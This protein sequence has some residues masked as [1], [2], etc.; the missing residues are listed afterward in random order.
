MTGLLGRLGRAD[1]LL[2]TALGW[3]LA[4]FLRYAFPPLFEPLQAVYGVSNAE[5]GAAFTGLM[6]VYAAM[7]FPSGLLADRLG[8]VTVITTGVLVAGAA[9]FALVVDSP[10]PVL[11]GAMLL[12]GAGTG[13][14]KTVAVRLLAGVYPSRTGWA[15]GVIDTFGAFGGVAAPATVV[16]FLGLPGV[17]GAP[18]RTLFLVAGLVAVALA[19]AFVVRAWTRTDER[20][21]ADAGGG[22]D[23]RPALRQYLALFRERRFAAFAALAVL[24]SFGYSGFV[25]FL[26]LYLTAEARLAASTAS[27][28]YSALFAVS[29][30]Q[31]LTGEASDRVG[32][33]PVVGVT[34]GVAT[35]ALVA[36]VLLTASGDAVLLGVAAV[37]MG[38]GAHG[39]RPV[40]GAYLVSIV[41]EATAGGSLGVVR[42]LL[43]AGGATSPAVV[44]YLSEAASFQVA[45][46]LLAGSLAV[47]TALAGLL[48][49]GDG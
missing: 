27:L 4:K 25:A 36:L 45:F 7:Q 31:V 30:V 9:S 28:I 38:L 34:L 12:V 21:D 11:V 44:G 32:E 1:L 46:W 10:F 26:P 43:M 8:S 19:A 33:L 35:V 13:V 40:R 2:L 14:H 37:C 6:V 22:P 20:T 48:W 16:L 15:V 39:Y 23:E 3:F 29:L 17:L 42:T 49:V 47:A 24:V 41:P 18:W 5:L